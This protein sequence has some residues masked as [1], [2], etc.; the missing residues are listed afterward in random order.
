ML[1]QAL[2][3]NLG[4]LGSDLLWKVLELLESGDALSGLQ[5]GRS[6]PPG[7]YKHLPGLTALPQF[8]VHW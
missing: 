7:C 8:F 6:G 5:A 2:P 4:S 1:Q 3:C